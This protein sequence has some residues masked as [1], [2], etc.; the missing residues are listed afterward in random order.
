MEKGCRGCSV[1]GHQPLP[2]AS[3][4]IGLVCFGEAVGGAFEGELAGQAPATAATI[5]H[6]LIELR[7]RDG[8]LDDGRDGGGRGRGSAR[9][10]VP[11]KR[12]GRSACAGRA[13]GPPGPLVPAG[14]RGTN[15][16]RALKRSNNNCVHVQITVG[17]CSRTEER[18][19]SSASTV[20][21]YNSNYVIYFKFT[22]LETRKKPGQAWLFLFSQLLPSLIRAFFSATNTASFQISA[23]VTWV[24]RNR[25]LIS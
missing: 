12:R 8:V 2:R 9:P 17:I 7:Q 14:Q 25:T 13:H 11:A 21:S 6:A 4:T 24:R 3:L 5:I 18:P 23:E 20:Q 16:G 1:P 15:Q 19:V 10:R 22:Y